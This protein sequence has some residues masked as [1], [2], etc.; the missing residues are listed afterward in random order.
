[1]T[2]TATQKG[3]EKDKPKPKKWWQRIP[4]R[5]IRKWTARLGVALLTCGNARGPTFETIF[6]T[7]DTLVLKYHPSLRAI[8]S[9]IA[10]VEQLFD[11]GD[12][13]V[14]YVRYGIVFDI[15]SALHTTI[16]ESLGSVWTP[17]F[18]ALST[19]YAWLYL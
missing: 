18:L 3:P 15:S 9:P 6:T 17:L 2:T 11:L 14:R 7:V 1:M 13:S 5:A 19:G 4:F 12:F 10:S 16:T 8:V